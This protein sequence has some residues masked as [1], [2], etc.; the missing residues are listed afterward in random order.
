MGKKLMKKPKSNF[1]NLKINKNKLTATKLITAKT[2]ISSKRQKINLIN[3]V[4]DHSKLNKIMK[5]TI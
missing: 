5:M 3:H 2:K 1:R 4:K